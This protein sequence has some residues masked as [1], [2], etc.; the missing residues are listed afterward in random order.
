MAAILGSKSTKVAEQMNSTIQLLLNQFI[1]AH[2]K[3]GEA[4][5][6][7]IIRQMEMAYW[8][9]QDVYLLKHPELR[10]KMTF[11][12]F[13]LTMII[14]YYKL[15]AASSVP[16]SIGETDQSTLPC[17]VQGDQ[18]VQVEGNVHRGEVPGDLD[19][20]ESVGLTA[21]P[22]LA[23]DSDVTIQELQVLC[24]RYGTYKRQLAVCGAI[25]L[26]Q[27][28]K[29]VLAV[30]SWP[31]NAWSFPKGKTRPDESD[32]ECAIREVKDSINFDIRPHIRSD[33]FF[34][35]MGPD[36]LFKY[37]LGPSGLGATMTRKQREL[38][39]R[40]NR[41]FLI[42][43]IDES[44]ILTNIKTNAVQSAH[45]AQDT[46]INGDARWDG[47]PSFKWIP[48]DQIPYA[49]C[50]IDGSSRSIVSLIRFER[51]IREW[52]SS[53]TI[54]DQ[55]VESFAGMC[56]ILAPRAPVHSSIMSQVAPLY[57]SN[58]TVGMGAVTSADVD[59]DV[60]QKSKKPTGLRVGPAVGSQHQ[61]KPLVRQQYQHY[62]RNYS[63]REFNGASRSDRS[64]SWR[65]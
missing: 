34:E 19:R 1:I 45:G 42:T 24:D 47:A 15:R 54:V 57:S 63:N 61:H 23:I 17:K 26:S 13:I 37:N 7:E 21:L 12:S 18:V 41:M 28:Q 46:K 5:E 32:V 22:K 60:E 9:Y 51:Q 27:D 25:L 30:R 56:P 8:Q 31:K 20:K 10:P 65:R 38:L 3:I 6:F 16:V 11:K 14:A 50:K 48:I 49:S 59:G 64:S 55:L 44:A 33:L 52:I 35:Q 58:M 40:R 62:H 36:Q 4:T 29:K 39:N 53:N 2:P 43:G